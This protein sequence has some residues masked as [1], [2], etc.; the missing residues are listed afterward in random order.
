MDLKQFAETNIAMIKEGNESGHNPDFK[1]KLTQFQEANSDL[2]IDSYNL[3][4]K[5]NLFFYINQSSCTKK[6]LKESPEG[7]RLTLHI[8]GGYIFDHSGEPSNNLEASAKISFLRPI[9]VNF[10]DLIGKRLY[11]V[12][13]DKQSNQAL[14]IYWNNDNNHK[15]ELKYKVFPAHNLLVEFS[16]IEPQLEQKEKSVVKKKFKWF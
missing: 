9:N 10:E 2:I 6:V 12:K 11:D 15:S 1:A 14:I 8:E 7:L 4:R 16:A 3:F 13:F 5:E